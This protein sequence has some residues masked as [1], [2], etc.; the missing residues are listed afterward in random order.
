MKT[1]QFISAA[2]ASNYDAAL[3]VEN[4]PELYHIKSWLCDCVANKLKRG[5]IPDFEQ[6]AASSTVGKML[7]MIDR[8][9]RALD[10]SKMTKE[11]R[12]EMRGMIA[13][14]VLYSAQENMA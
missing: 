3:I 9:L 12:K 7:T 11:E 6:L 5:I 13:N 14:N 10:C 8:E 1:Y 2:E 4:T